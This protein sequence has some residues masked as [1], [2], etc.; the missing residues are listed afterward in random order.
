MELP[1]NFLELSETELLDLKFKFSNYKDEVK[2]KC[3]AISTRLAEL[4]AIKETAARIANM[5]PE[6][7]EVWKKALG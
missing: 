3:V 2:S 5:R 7:K 1:T 6:E 4:S